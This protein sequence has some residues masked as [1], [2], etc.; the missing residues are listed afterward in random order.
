MILRLNDSFVRLCLFISERILIIHFEHFPDRCHESLHSSRANMKQYYTNPSEISVVSTINSVRINHR[1]HSRHFE[2]EIF[3]SEL[4]HG[5]SHT[6]DLEPIS[7]PWARAEPRGGR[8]TQNFGS[9]FLPHRV[10]G[11][12]GMGFEGF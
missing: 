4:S 7:T 10:H 6:S 1:P 3:H 8:K 2:S 12:L 5:L 11:V 9:V